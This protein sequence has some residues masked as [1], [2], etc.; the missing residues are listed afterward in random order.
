MKTL[1]W[2]LVACLVIIVWMTVALVRVENQRY[3]LQ[4]GM[5]RD[6]L[7]GTTNVR[8]LLEVESRTHWWSHLFYALTD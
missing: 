1:R 8:C 7:G 3:A 2:S 5:C 6:G 4:I